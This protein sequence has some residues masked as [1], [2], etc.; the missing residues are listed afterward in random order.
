VNRSERLTSLL[1][2]PASLWPAL[3]AKPVP[4]GQLYWDYAVPLVSL[5]FLAFLLGDLLFGG[6]NFV[7]GLVRSIVAYAVI[8]AAL[9]VASHV[10][11]QLARR[12]GGRPSLV[13]VANL[14]VFAAVP[15]CL[16]GLAR[17]LPGLSLV[18]VLG[19]LYGLYLFY[20]G[21]GTML[22]CP[23]DKTFGLT[24]ASALALVLV[25]SVLTAILA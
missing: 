5:P 22:K 1:L 7:S 20:Q 23:A 19:L 2:R 8:L 24:L 14:L 4:L 15:A 16:A 12:V 3:A 11:A 17:L 13:A 25:W 9:Y 10:I 6:A 18:P 21:A